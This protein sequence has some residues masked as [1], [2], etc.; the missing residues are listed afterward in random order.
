[1]SLTDIDICKRMK[2]DIK[3][4]NVKKLERKDLHYITARSVI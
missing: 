4:D 1:V 3:V 2:F